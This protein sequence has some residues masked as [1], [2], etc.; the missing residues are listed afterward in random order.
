ML[1]N[2]FQFNL[3]FFT[4]DTEHLSIC[5]L[6][7]YIPSGDHLFQYIVFILICSSLLHVPPMFS[8][9]F[10]ASLALYKLMILIDYFSPLFGL[11]GVGVLL[12][13]MLKR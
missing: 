10:M 4:S 8:P 1:L 13:P 12:S 11:I 5:L 2:N 3:Y 6:A 7:I 9:M